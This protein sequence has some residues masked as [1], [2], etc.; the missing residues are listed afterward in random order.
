M[1][2]LP[3]ERFWSVPDDAR[4]DEPYFVANVYRMAETYDADRMRLTRLPDPVFGSRFDYGGGTRTEDLI[5][6]PGAQGDAHFWRDVF[7]DT[8][9]CD[10]VFRAAVE[11]VAPG[12]YTFKAT[13]PNT[14]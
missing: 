1:E 13:T 6:R 10:D 2:L 12:T 7:T 8:F 5:V 11:G 9:F 14:G 4:I 3:I